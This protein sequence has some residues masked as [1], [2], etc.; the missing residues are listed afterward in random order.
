[1]VTINFRKLGREKIEEG[2]KWDLGR[3]KWDAGGR[4]VGGRG[5]G[6]GNC[7]PPVHLFIIIFSSKRSQ[8]LTYKM[9]MLVYIFDECSEL[10]SI[11]SEYL[12]L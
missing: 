12:K 1:M 3:G 10:K 6:S 2:R 9:Y 5:E 11:R 4:E 8:N 7:L